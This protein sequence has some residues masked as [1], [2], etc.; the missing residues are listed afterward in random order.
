M[1]QAWENTFRSWGAA[2]SATE[3]EKMENAE[4]AIRKAITADSKLSVMN[5]S[6]IPQGSYRSKTNVRL[7]SDVDIAVCLNS[8]FFTRYPAGKTNEDYGNTAS[9][10]SYSQFRS[11]VTAALSNYFGDQHTTPGNKAIDVHSNS[12]R[13]DADV[14]PA[15]AYR[16]YH[17]EGREQFIEPTGV[18]FDTSDGKRI[19]N[20]P[21]QTYANG[22]EKHNGTGQRFRK[23]VRIVKRLR[24]RMQEK[25]ITSAVDIGS[26]LIESMVWNAPDT[27]FGNDTYFADVREVMAHCFND[28]LPNGRHAELCEVNDIK[29]LF[30]QHQAWTLERAH[31]FFSSAWDHVGFN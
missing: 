26:F 21:E 28:T 22:L 31:A 23:L 16:Y 3:Q 18:S 8:T 27:A 4:T 9:P 25:G 24:N 30:G 2:P 15:L 7:D 1:N 14:V 5:I 11:L 17:G 20:W 10:I 6:I 12:Y 13:V 29:L 19:I